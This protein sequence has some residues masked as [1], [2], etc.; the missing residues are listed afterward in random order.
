[1]TFHPTHRVIVE[2]DEHEYALST[3]LKM[4]FSFGERVE[5]AWYVD[6][7]GTM[8]IMNSSELELL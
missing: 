4:S 2:N 8:Q 7:E 3:L 5:Y 6:E 1:M